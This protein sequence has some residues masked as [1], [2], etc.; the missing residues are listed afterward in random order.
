MP[1]FHH[2]QIAF[3]YADEGEGLPLILLHGL[4]ADMAQ[5]LEIAPTRDGV[6]LLRM[7]MRGH[8]G[9]YPL[10]PEDGFS[11]AQMASDVLALADHL[12]LE[13][14]VIGGISMGAGISLSLATLQPGRVRGLILIRPAWLDGSSPPTLEV[15][16]EAG[17]CIQQY[18]VI[19]GKA[20][21]EQLMLYQQVAAAVP[22]AARGLLAQFDH[23]RAAEA[24]VRLLRIP[25]D[26]PI[27]DR[28][29]WSRLPMPA[30]VIGNGQDPTHPLAMAQAF[31]G[32]I[33]NAHLVEVPPKAMS[34][35]AHNQAVRVAIAAW[36]D[37]S[38]LHPQG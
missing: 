31:A 34:V 28:A 1:T 20:R 16:R 5:P 36:L 10:G 13:Q 15:M 24:V 14:F 8:G 22:Y 35:E 27:G 19:A 17:H 38:F 18:G 7:D 9:T 4:T 2:D 25:A 23:P 32:W 33:P 30:L 3:N 11:F 12:G 29:A 21:F 37:S 26:K 6:R